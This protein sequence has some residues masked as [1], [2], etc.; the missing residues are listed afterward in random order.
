MNRTSLGHK[1]TFPHEVFCTQRANIFQVQC[2]RAQ[3]SLLNSSKLMQLVP[4]YLL[5]L[6]R[7]SKPF[8]PLTLALINL[9]K[10]IK[11]HRKWRVF[12]CA[13]MK[14]RYWLNQFLL[15]SCPLKMYL[16][17][18]MES[19][20]QENLRETTFRLIIATRLESSSGTQIM[21]SDPDQIH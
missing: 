15:L 4:F 7:N 11:L 3:S 19:Y 16:F 14:P 18:S 2:M 8:Y 6:H 17:V 5:S 1:Q 10:L 13:S 9:L 21:A 12:I 20:Q